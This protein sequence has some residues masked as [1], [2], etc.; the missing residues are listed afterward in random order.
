MMLEKQYHEELSLELQGVP[1]TAALSNKSMRVSNDNDEVM[2]DTSTTLDQAAEDANNLARI[3][4][5]RKNRNL[6]D[7]IQVLFLFSY[8]LSLSL[9]AVLV[10]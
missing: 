9:S 8:S 10:F 7:A 2:Q 5:S 3:T 1:Y 4:M 6:Y